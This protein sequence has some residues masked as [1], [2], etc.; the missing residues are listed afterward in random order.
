M[1][2]YL[3]KNDVKVLKQT[4][5]TVNN[6][7]T[8]VGQGKRPTIKNAFA[9]AELTEVDA[10]GLWS[11]VEVYF[12]ETGAPNGLEDGRTWGGEEPS[13]IVNGDVSA[14]QVMRIEAHYLVDSSDNEQAVWIG[15]AVGGG[16]TDFRLQMS[17]S[18]G[19]EK[20]VPAPN[21]A[22]VITDL[23][24]VVESGVTVIQRVFDTA[25]IYD[26]VLFGYIDEEGYYCIDKSL[27]GI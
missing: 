1:S 12:D 25:R 15:S 16:S 13:I 14:G 24:E 17:E 21:G 2:Y 11:A 18:V 26:E 7:S 8:G 22:D 3:S 10:D 5:N 9:Y 6:I 23:G 20:N 27:L 4:I 19:L